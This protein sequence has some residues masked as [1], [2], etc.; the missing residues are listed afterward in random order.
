[1]VGPL[2]ELI[3]PRATTVAFAVVGLLIFLACLLRLRKLESILGVRIFVRKVPALSGHSHAVLEGLASRMTL[4]K[5]LGRTAVVR[6]GEVGDRLYIVKE[7]EAGSAGDAP[8]VGAKG[9][10]RWNPL[11][12]SAGAGGSSRRIPWASS[13]QVAATGCYR[14]QSARKKPCLL[15]R[16]WTRRIA[17]EAFKHRF[18]TALEGHIEKH[19]NRWPEEG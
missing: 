5:V 10:I 18:S 2:I 14:A 4:E 8:A 7:D 11:P 1:V 16:P 17:A 9:S 3:G 13:H 19:A 6:E 12:V 15:D